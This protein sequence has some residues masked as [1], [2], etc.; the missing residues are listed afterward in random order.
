MSARVVFLGTPEAAVP[1]LEELAG[2]HSVGLVITQPA[3]PRGR[4]NRPVSPPVGMSAAAL[5]L[6]TAWPENGEQLESAIRDA[7]PFDLGIVVAYGRILGPGALDLPTHGFLNVHFSLLPR[8]RGAAPVARALI[9]GDPMT[10]V[11]II[12][13]DQGLD[14]G[15]VLTAQAID[16]SR[17]EN[18]GQLT[19]RLAGLGARLLSTSIDPYLRGVLE[20]VPQTDEGLTYAEKI[21]SRDRSID[22]GADVTTVVNQV[23]GLAP[24]PAAT[25]DIDGVRHKILRVRACDAA[26]ERATWQA[27]GGVPVIGLSNGGIEILELQPAG[28]TAQIGAEWVRGRRRDRGVVS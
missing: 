1:A 17:E 28:R 7:G 23:R 5:G 3:R 9:A 22:T 8:W 13:L 4:S 16:I 6:R 18:A 12:K 21:G 25:L 2:A 27:V 14:T 11:T 24:A 20:P 10:G 26:P 19:D 15:P